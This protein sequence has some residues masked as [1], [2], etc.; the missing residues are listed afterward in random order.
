MRILVTGSRN[1]TDE[2]VVARALAS[3]SSLQDMQ[4][5]AVVHGGAKGADSLAEAWCQRWKVPTE[6]HKPDYKAYPGPVAPLRR[7]DAMLDSGI[8]LVVAFR[9]GTPTH[10]GTQYTIDGAAKRR[11]PTIIYAWPG[12]AE[13]RD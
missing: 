9:L 11:I 6:V 12:D 13:Y 3:L 5:F 2:R 4:P 10:G 7:N 8:D 1:W